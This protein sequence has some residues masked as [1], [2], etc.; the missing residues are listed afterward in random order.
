MLTAHL[1]G[2]FVRDSRK[3]T[4]ILLLDEYPEL[5]YANHRLLEGNRTLFLSFA[6]GFGNH[7]RT[8]DE[9]AEDVLSDL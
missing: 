1:L 5:K 7:R 6:E 4:C 2:W 8:R 3:D 9:F